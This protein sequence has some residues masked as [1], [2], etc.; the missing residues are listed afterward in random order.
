MPLT[1]K[2]IEELIAITAIDMPKWPIQDALSMLASCKSDYDFESAV[3]FI[4][5]NYSAEEI[6]E[7]IEIRFEGIQRWMKVLEGM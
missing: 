7:G 6:Q 2:D 1:N 3:K 4:R 5:E